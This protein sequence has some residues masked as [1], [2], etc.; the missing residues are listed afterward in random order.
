MYLKELKVKSTF[1][2]PEDNEWIELD[3]GHPTLI[4]GLVSKG[5]N[6][7]RRNHWVTKYKISY[8][9]DSVFWTFYK[10]ANHLEAKTF[11]ANADKQMERAHFLN[12]PFWARYVR[13]YPLEWN[14]QIG[15]RVGLIGC[16]F[17]GQCFAGYFR[18]NENANC[19]ENVA[20]RK[21][22][23]ILG[24]K[25]RDNWYSRNSSGWSLRSFRSSLLGGDRV[26]EQ[27]SHLSNVV[28]GNEDNSLAKCAIIS[29]LQNE[30]PTLVIDLGRVV[31][32]AGLVIKTWQGRMGNETSSQSKF[33]F[34]FLK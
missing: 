14:E 30:R 23:W 3:V 8:S 28:D 11:G 16:P 9:N 33:K 1:F 25:S 6:D 17:S 7:Q 5:R 18:V 34:F 4:T 15:M 21:D 27:D 13:F 22:T 32:V 12:N 29:S 20:Y 10:D 2:P 19:V 24:G 31:N 26:A